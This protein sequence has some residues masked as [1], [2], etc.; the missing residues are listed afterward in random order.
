MPDPIHKDRINKI[1][2][3]AGPDVI[4]QIGASVHD[5]A[6]KGGE[7][8]PMSRRDGLIGNYP[9]FTYPKKQTPDP[10][11]AAAIGNGASVASVTEE[12][13]PAI[14]VAKKDVDAAK[15]KRATEAEAERQAEKEKEKSAPKVEGI[16]ANRL[17]STKAMEE[18]AKKDKIQPPIDPAAGTLAQKK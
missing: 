14:K 13:G 9:M 1:Q 16:E 3:V 12:D 15:E 7:A 6:M 18:N 4:D 8:N 5:A 10:T 2:S 11:A 17:A